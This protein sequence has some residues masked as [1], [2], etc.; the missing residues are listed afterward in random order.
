MTIE[1]A[2]IPRVEAAGQGYGGHAQGFSAHPEPKRK[3]QQALFDAIDKHD[4]VTASHLFA[5]LM[6]LEPSFRGDAQWRALGHA[7]EQG[8]LYVA[9]HFMKAL[10]SKASEA[11][12]HQDHA[13][14]AVP[15]PAPS[16]WVDPEH[17]LC[18]N[19]QA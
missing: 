19:V 6:N 18:V 17:G 12:L 2:S 10:Q 16:P 7:L 1:S 13:S 4:L 3:K 8:E 5:A 15:T 14:A 11:A 9:Q